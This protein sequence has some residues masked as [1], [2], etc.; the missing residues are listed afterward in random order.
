M[1]TTTAATLGVGL[2]SID[3]GLQADLNFERDYPQMAAL[4]GLV[5]PAPRRVRGY[6]DGQ[7]V[8]D[9]IHARYVWEWANY[10]QYYVP[11]ADVDLSLLVDE[12]HE[13]RLRFGTARRHGLRTAHAGPARQCPRL[14]DG[15]AS[16]AGR[17]REVRLG[18]PGRVVRGGRAGVRPPAQ[19]LRPGRRIALAPLG[20]GR[21]RRR[22]ARRIRLVR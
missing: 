15:C 4:P 19:P 10:P 22:R 16:R 14:R 20:P 11:L 18:R 3:S 5:E 17:Y 1:A 7:Q 12:D 13:Q 21:A 6:L 2:M 8:F 9:T